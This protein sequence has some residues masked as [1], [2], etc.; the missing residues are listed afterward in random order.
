MAKKSLITFVLATSLIGL[1]GCANN[2]NATDN[3]MGSNNVHNN[4]E[5]VNFKNVR[6]DVNNRHSV[7]NVTNDNLRVSNRAIDKV[8]DLSEVNQAHVI[9][10]NNDA[11]VAVRL[12]G[13]QN[14]LGGTNNRSNNRMGVANNGKKGS[15]SGTYLRTNGKDR[16]GTPGA[17]VGFIDG[18]GGTTRIPD[19]N[20]RNNSGTPSSNRGTIGIRGSG[21]NGNAAGIS[22]NATNGNTNG[23]G[24]TSYK[25]VSNPLEQRIADQV[26]AADNSIHK[27]YVSYDTDFFDQ[28]TTYANDINAG[29]NRDG[30]WND[31][32]NSIGRIFR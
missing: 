26:R 14:T 1:T 10:R 19:T 24:K 28:M 29:R 23:M 15:T 12:N 27:V 18:N 2:N 21:N 20:G 9:V 3:N 8:E 5:D 32:K 16:N 17:G 4:N 6:N 22:G 7:R 13:N 11:Y 31:F 30:I 25:E